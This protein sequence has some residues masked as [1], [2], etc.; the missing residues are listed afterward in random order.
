MRE[1]VFS[2]THILPYKDRPWENTGQK[3]IILPYFIQYLL[4]G[5]TPVS[6]SQ[7][8]HHLNLKMGFF[9]GNFVFVYN[10]TKISHLVAPLSVKPHEN[11]KRNP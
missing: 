8:I 3:A 2:L 10:G 4:P 6:T 11:Q 9:P 5:Y 7:K 1:Y